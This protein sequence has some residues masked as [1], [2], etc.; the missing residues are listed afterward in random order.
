MLPA[1]A[2]TPGLLQD[3]VSR[4]QLAFDDED[5]EDEEAVKGAAGGAA[6]RVCVDP[7][8]AAGK[9]AVAPQQQQ[10][11]SWD[12]GEAAQLWWNPDERQINARHAWT[13]P[14]V[15]LW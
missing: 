14:S 7:P 2:R 15:K 1:A 4:M 3:T 8:E 10:L 12:S 11:C 5:D 13:R 6:A 9:Q